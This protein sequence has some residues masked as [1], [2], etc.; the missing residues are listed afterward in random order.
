MH[1]RKQLKMARVL[2]SQH[3]FW[4]SGW[5][6]RLQTLTWS[7]LGCCDHLVSQLAVRRWLSI[8]LSFISSLSLSV[9]PSLYNSAV[10]INKSLNNCFIY[11]K[12]TGWEKKRID[13]R[14]DEMKKESERS[15][16]LC[17]SFPPKACNGQGWAWVS[18]ELRDATQ[19]S[20]WVL[21]N[22]SFEPPLML[23]RY[24]DVLWMEAGGKWDSN[25]TFPIWSTG[26]LPVD[27]CFCPRTSVSL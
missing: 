13:E 3:P 2:G 23:R 7:S 5:S 16:L 17:W 15:C 21:G 20:Q 11:L 1:P 19:F 14:G 6:F 9:S 4:R 25:I 26:T 22:H 24:C 10:Q 27:K 18:Q 12:G 8:P